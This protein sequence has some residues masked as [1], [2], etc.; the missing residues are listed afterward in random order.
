[1]NRLFVMICVRVCAG[2][3][4]L[5]SSLKRKK[6][7]I[8]NMFST[9]V[10]HL[11]WTWIPVF[12]SCVTTHNNHRRCV[13]ALSHKNRT[14]MIK[15]KNKNPKK[16]F[17]KSTTCVLVSCKAKLWLYAKRPS[18]KCDTNTQICRKSF[19]QRIQWWDFMCVVMWYHR[20]KIHYG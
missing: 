15:Y 17:D 6:E 19:G 2:K 1:M 12:I 3:F 4:L 5:S 7:I 9:S 8:Y 16:I 13:D 14:I 10:P 18:I 20:T 11:F